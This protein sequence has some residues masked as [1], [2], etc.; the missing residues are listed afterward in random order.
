MNL[1][2]AGILHR[3]GAG[4]MLRTLKPYLIGVPAGLVVWIFICIVV[5]AFPPAGRPIAVLAVGGT[6]AAL[7]AV[8]AAGGEVLEVRDGRVVAISDDPGFVVRLYGETP[9]IA[10]LSEGGCG[11][12]RSKAVEARAKD[13]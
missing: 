4:A 10:V 1:T 3:G 5:S 8:V 9:L 2:E 12:G 13:V 7:D 6:E 11:F